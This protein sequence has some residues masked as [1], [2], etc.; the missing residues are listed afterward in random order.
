MENITAESLRE[1]ISTIFGERVLSL[2]DIGLSRVPEAITD[3]T[4]L[5]ELYLSDNYLT[6]L[7]ASINKLTNLK[8]LILG[9]I[10]N[11]I[12]G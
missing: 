3:L 4:E 5:E 1:L 6:E 9:I 11:W 8:W 12:I 2:S 7:P 10:K